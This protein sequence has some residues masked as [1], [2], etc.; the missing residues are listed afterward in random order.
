MLALG[1]GGQAA[2]RARGFS[3]GSAGNVSRGGS[4]QGRRS[5]E[6]MGI[7]EEDEEEEEIEEVEEFSPVIGGVEEVVEEEEGETETG[8]GAE[9]PSEGKGLGL[10]E[11]MVEAVRG[12]LL[13]GRL[14]EEEEEGKK[15]GG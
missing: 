15:G 5:G 2:N 6:I 10:R 4:V 12:E 9:S 7:T 11:E 1:T 8:A 13:L 3:D 14:L